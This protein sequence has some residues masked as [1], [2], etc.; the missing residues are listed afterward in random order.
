MDKAFANRVVLYIYR[1]CIGHWSK[2]LQKLE[3]YVCD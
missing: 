2:Y 1:S 3:N